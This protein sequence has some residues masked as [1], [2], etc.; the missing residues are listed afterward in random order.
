MVVVAVH[1]RLDSRAELVQGG[2]GMPV[3][4]LVFEDGP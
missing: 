2:E 3:V 4:V 1:E